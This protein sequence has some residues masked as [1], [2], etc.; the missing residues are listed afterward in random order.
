MRIAVVRQGHFEYDPRVQREVHALLQAGHD[1][2]VISRRQEGRPWIEHDAALTVRRLPVPLRRGGT[3]SYL[4]DYAIFFVMAFTLLT[5]LHIRRRYEL[6]QVHSLP[7]PLVFAAIVP[8]LTGARVVLDLHEC[9]PEFFATKFGKGLDHRAVRAVAA[10]EQ[11]SIRFADFVLTCT[12]Q[13]R[14]AFVGRGADPAKIGV[15]HNTAE[16][17]I[18][19]PERHPPRAREHGPFTLICHGSVEDRYGLDTAIKAVASLADEIPELRLQILGKGTQLPELR[20]LAAQL[21]VR[22]RVDFNG[23]WIPVE[24]LVNAIAAADAGIVAMKRDIF[25]DLVHCNKMYDLIAMRRP[26]I[27]SRTRSVEA[28]FSGDA[29]LYFRAD[30]PDDLARAIRQLHADPGLGERLVEQAQQEVE[31]YR[32]PRQ[33]ELYKRYVLSTASG[34]RPADGDV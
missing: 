20:E 4:A 5:L 30:D 2:D 13:M 31:P 29:L 16:E 21:D 9:M 11:A 22:D 18:F 3:V 15:V 17:E 7:D 28:Y 25:R 33:R 14:E 12:D 23:A 34:S 1:V 8:K 26:V 24:E 19:D 6:V 27:T 10:A 32:W